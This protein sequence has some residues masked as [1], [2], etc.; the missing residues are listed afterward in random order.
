MICKHAKLTDQK[1]IVC[2]LGRYGGMPHRGICRQC[3]E[4]SEGK[5]TIM[6]F[7]DSEHCSSRSHCRTCRTNQK[8]R[9][10]IMSAFEWDGE[11]PYDEDE[12]NYQ[13]AKSQKPLTSP[14]KK[15]TCR[16]TGTEC[17]QYWGCRDTCRV[18]DQRITSM[19]GICPRE[20]DN[21]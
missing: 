1:K 7:I 15:K 6:K 3:N 12:K 11:C 19:D 16:M 21:V 9:D 13:P 10:S 4:F 20:N 14:C 18:V 2:S 5:C 17:D 8:W